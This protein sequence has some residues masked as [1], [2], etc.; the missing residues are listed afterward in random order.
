[1]NGAFNENSITY[2]P[3]FFRDFF[4]TS[5]PTHVFCLPPTFFLEATTMNN[6][7]PIFHILRVLVLSLG[8]FFF[9]FEIAYSI[10]RP[11]TS[12]ASGRIVTKEAS[13]HPYRN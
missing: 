12:C 4:S 2:S 8:F 11:S 7:F 1:M 6:L 9:V 13:Q 5:S 3:L 10:D